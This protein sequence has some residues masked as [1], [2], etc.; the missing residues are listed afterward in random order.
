M[1]P[2]PVVTEPEPV[3]EP[4]PPKPERFDLVLTDAG[5]DVILV[6]REARDATGVSLKDVRDLLKGGG[7]TLQGGLDRATAE[8]LKDRLVA[9]GAQAEVRR[10]ETSPP[11]AS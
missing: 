11:D 6:F 9:V 5:D 10:Q 2:P 1:E 4:P 8:A 7:G 3:P